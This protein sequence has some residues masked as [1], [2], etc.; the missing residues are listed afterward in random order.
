MLTNNHVIED[1]P[2][3]ALD[4]LEASERDLVKSH[5]STCERCRAELKAYQETVAQLAI[6][7]PLH[8]PP[9]GLKS[10]ILQK[11]SPNPRHSLKEIF[12]TWFRVAPALSSASIFLIMVL[13]ATNLFLWRQSSRPAPME[14]HGYAAVTLDSTQYA[15]GSTGL[16]IYTKDGKSGFLVVNN[17]E[18]LTTDKQYQLWLI[19]GEKR[20][21]GGVFSVSPS[22]YYVMEIESLT[23]LTGFDSFGITIEPSG[24][25][26]GPTGP[27]VL[28]GKF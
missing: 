12:F 23:P 1:L 14:Q 9:A 22:G 6:V 7:T 27:K 25:S 3:Y 11:I 4:I 19:Q 26:P 5:L 18:K 21:S 10:T 15:P 24:G 17:L 20:V 13:L 28:G 2:A 8:L 16:V